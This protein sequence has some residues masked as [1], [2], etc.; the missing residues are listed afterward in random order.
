MS[1]RDW[2]GNSGSSEIAII[3]IRYDGLDAE[4]HQIDLGALGESLQGIAKGGCA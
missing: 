4:Q 3:P 1:A 2:S